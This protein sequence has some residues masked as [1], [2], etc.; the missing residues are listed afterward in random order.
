MGTTHKNKRKERDSPE[1]AQLAF[2]SPPEHMGLNPP[3][4]R[5]K[6]LVLASSFKN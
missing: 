3:A 4:D 5:E 1:T 2:S 6:Y